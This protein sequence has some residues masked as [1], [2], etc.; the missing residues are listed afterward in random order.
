MFVSAI[1]LA[2]GASSRFGSL[3]MLAT[4]EGEPLVRRSA[5]TFLEAGLGET[6]VVVGAHAEEVCSSLGALPVRTVVNPNWV[7]GML[8]SMRAGLAA[9]DDRATH[10]AVSPSDLP[11]LTPGV[12]RKLVEA[13]READPRTIV[14][15]GA[16]GRRGHPMIFDA[17]L[18]ERIECW[19]KDARLSDLL[20]QPDLKVR[21]VDGFDASILRD[22]DRP[23][24]LADGSKAITAL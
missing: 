2:A 14:V 3:K 13:A 7:D 18:R 20:R 11:G 5:R 15:P 16:N 6:I 22:V 23:A 1:L 19:P 12:V 9:L 8:S 21:V 17:T 10:V 4:I 24:D